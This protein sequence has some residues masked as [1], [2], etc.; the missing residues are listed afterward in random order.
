MIKN[1]HHIRH[2]VVPVGH[3]EELAADV[4]Q[5]GHEGAQAD[6]HALQGDHTLHFGD[7][8]GGGRLAGH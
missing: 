3:G 6:D 7:G 2:V 1:P 8:A 5:R 4:E